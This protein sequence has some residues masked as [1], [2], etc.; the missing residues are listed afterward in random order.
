[1][2]MQEAPSNEDP[3]VE[4][5]RER[6]GM[7]LQEKWTLE[8]LLGVGGM[9][10][11]YAAR[12]RNGKRVAVKMLHPEMSHDADV[13]SRFLAE[14]YA[15]NT[16]AHEGAV[17]VLDDDVAS[18]GSAFIVMELLEGETVEQ[19]WERSGQQLPVQEVLAIVDQ[20]LDVLAAAHSKNV[21]HRDIK[22]ENLF[23]TR[24]GVLKVLDFGIAKVF[25]AQRG[26]ATST[27]AGV[28]MGTPAFM[29][30]EQARARWDEVDGRTDL[31]A[32]GATMFTLLSGRHVHEGESGNEQLILSATTPPRSLTS[33]V[34]GVPP[35]VV[36]I[37]DRAL[38]FERSRRWPEAQAMR[39]AVSAAFLALGGGDAVP[40]SL[41]RAPTS[42]VLSRSGTMAAAA[43]PATAS[44]ATTSGA[45][46]T[47]IDT[48]GTTSAAK[49]WTQE[50]ET[51]IAESSRLRANVSELQQRVAGARKRVGEGQ[52]TVEAARGERASLEQW[53]KRQA[54]TRTAAVEEARQLVRDKL[55]AL[56]RRACDD[57]AVFGSDLDGPREQIAKLQ[58]ACASAQR[59]V[60]VHE[61]A[62]EAYDSRSLRL[63]VLLLGVAAALVL[64]LLVAPV[65]WR[66]TRV[67]EPPPPAPLVN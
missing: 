19:R 27:R 15:A 54:G 14:G 7:V 60:T 47:L 40:S 63:G 20:L 48:T 23:L 46:A 67:V 32:V 56:A 30:P 21:V 66:A 2:T 43:S 36:A 49:A 8:A 9:A 65:V 55:I 62:L 12:H 34:R 64:A 28:V 59:D 41:R 10:A 1:M 31:W 58:A 3:V 57:R 13:K 29:A 50:R 24:S 52:G 4:R 44:P 18:D 42:T 45:A 11:V 16:I 25:E 38:A 61:T 37:V 35:A 5:A 26:R 51:R 6:L 17:S 53:F 22:P 39:Q 33:V